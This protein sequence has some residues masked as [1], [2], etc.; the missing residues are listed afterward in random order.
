MLETKPN[1]YISRP[2]DLKDYYP[3]CIPEA[4]PQAKPNI[5]LLWL[6]H[7]ISVYTYAVLKIYK[8]NT[9]KSM[10]MSYAYQSS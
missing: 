8:D 7:T 2:F 4:N 3:S 9:Q 1:K 10:Q 6:T 5:K